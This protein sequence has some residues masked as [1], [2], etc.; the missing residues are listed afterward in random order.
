MA[1]YTDYE[2]Q[3]LAKEEIRDKADEFRMKYWKSEILPVDIE[4]IIENDLILNIIPEHDIRKLLQIDAYLQSNLNSIV[5]DLEHYMKNSYDNRI[6]FSFAHEVGHFVLHKYIYNNFNF[7]SRVEYKDFMNEF[8]N[9]QYSYFEYQAN[10]FAGR[11][12]V[13]RERLIL[14][15]R[16]V[17]EK[18][19]KYNSLL[20]KLEENPEMVLDGTI[21]DL[22]KPFGVSEYVIRIR[23]ERE[24]LWPP[25]LDI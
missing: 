25:N 14:E 2:C 4:R 20:K 11:L 9:E 13:P 10:E 18:I 7:N 19:R 21:Q 5:V 16:E 8:P 23:V 17:Y 3:Y 12:L 22:C 24:G 15:I 6:R 1:E